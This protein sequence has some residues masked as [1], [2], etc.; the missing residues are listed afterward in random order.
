MS[1]HS[2]WAGIKHKKALIDAKKG[3][4]FTKLIREITMAAR[5]GGGAQDANPRLRTAILKAK[6]ANM[7]SDN[8]DR[9]IKKGTG[10]LPGMTIEEMTYEGYGL[11]GVAIIIEAMTD[12]KNR[13]TSEIRNI[14]SKRGG[15]LAGSGAVSWIFHKKGYIMVDKKTA[16][17]DKVMSIALDSG[18]EDFVIGEESYEI[19]TTPQDFEKVKNAIEANKIAFQVAEITMIPTNSVKLEGDAARKVL[20]LVEE[21]EDHDDVQHVYAN[22]DIPDSI[23]NQD[24]EGK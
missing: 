8:I 13:T 22:F 17:E 20:G 6:E 11:N 7:P 9:A 5:Q 12:N 2:K 21:L 14:L 4:V 24:I 1:G 16:E 15:N 10:E 23:M 19:T 3:K 18:A